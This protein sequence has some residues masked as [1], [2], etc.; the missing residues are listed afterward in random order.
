MSNYRQRSAAVKRNLGAGVC[1]PHPAAKYWYFDKIRIW[2]KERLPE[3][4]IDWLREHCRGGLYEEQER[5]R[6]RWDPR[7]VMCLQLY[8]PDDEA[9]RWLAKLGGVLLN[10]AECA[11]D[12]VFNNKQEADAAN[13]LIRRYHIKRRHGS[14]LVLFCRG[15]TRYSGPRRAANMLVM[16]CDKECRRTGEVYCLHL[17]WRMSG[18][19][20]LER[21]GLGTVE[22]L[23]EI[24]HHRFWKERLL[25]RTVDYRAL[26]RMYRVRIL[27]Q[28]RGRGRTWDSKIGCSVLRAVGSAA[29]RGSVQSLVDRYRRRFD[30]GRCLV[31]LPVDGFLPNV[32]GSDED[33]RRSTGSEIWSEEQEVAGKIVGLGPYIIA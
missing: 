12:L 17:E 8:Q 26:G 21:A 1:L 29:V 22:Q 2:L 9:L 5:E 16:Y 25:L 32:A 18:V 6:K 13:E 11:L 24:D 20:S 30:I 33:R 4:R 7:Y 31:P 28:R 23:L 19:Q 3:W 10:Y 27:G 15:I 14:Q